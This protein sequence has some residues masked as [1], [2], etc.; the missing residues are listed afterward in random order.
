[1]FFLFPDREELKDKLLLMREGLA[2]LPPA[3]Y[4]TLKYVIG[5][6]VR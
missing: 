3:H 1:M 6:L 4:Q 5:H 2:I